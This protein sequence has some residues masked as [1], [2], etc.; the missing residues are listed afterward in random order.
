M[1]PGD[2]LSHRGYVGD[3]PEREWASL[4]LNHIKSKTKKLNEPHFAHASRYD[5][6]V[7]DNTHLFLADLE[8]AS[9]LLYGLVAAW[10]KTVGFPRKFST[11]SVL[12]DR[13]LLFD[14]LDKRLILPV[15][16]VPE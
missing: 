2:R 14:I 5:L 7:Y 13:A 8:E 6:V 15:N 3:K 12:R 16:L 9:T 4:V 1:A 10:R 11:I